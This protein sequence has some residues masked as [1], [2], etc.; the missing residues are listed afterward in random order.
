MLLLMFP[1]LLHERMQ[2]P[3]PIS[4]REG[5]STGLTSRIGVPSKASRARTRT[6]FPSIDYDLHHVQPDRVRVGPA[7]GC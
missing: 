4:A 7:S 1:P 6:R 2:L 3:T 5:S